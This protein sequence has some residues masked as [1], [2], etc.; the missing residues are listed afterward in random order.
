MLALFAIVLVS[1]TGV[2]VSIA[3]GGIVIEFDYFCKL[4]LTIK[5]RAS[6]NVG[7]LTEGRGWYWEDGPRSD[8]AWVAGL[9]TRAVLASQRRALVT[10]CLELKTFQCVLIVVWGIDIAPDSSDHHG[11]R[12][13]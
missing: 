9:P 13:W 12:A 2:P 4:T 3:Y 10:P 6:G 1:H 7:R 5:N 11:C 8:R